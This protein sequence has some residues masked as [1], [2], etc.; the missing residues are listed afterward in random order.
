M[1]LL[2]EFKQYLTLNNITTEF[3]DEE[4]ELLLNNKVNELITY[5]GIE[6]NP[7][8]HT[9]FKRGFSDDIYELDFYPIKEISELKV[10]GKS[11]TSDRYT[12]DGERGVLYFNYCL[13]GL[14]FCKY[15]SGVSETVFD[16]KVKPLLFDMAGYTLKGENS[17]LGTVSSIKEGDVQVNYDTSTSLGGLIVSRLNNLKGMYSCRVKVI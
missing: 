2:T 1:T 4:L 16:T 5:T 10:D 17:L 7:V 12:C 6:I 14:L 9:E 13:N 8:T 15:V 3:T 11:I